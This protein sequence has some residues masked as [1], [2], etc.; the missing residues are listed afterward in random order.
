MTRIRFEINGKKGHIALPTFT[1]ATNSVLSILT[2][3]G[4]AVP[5]NETGRL[6][7]YIDDLS[8]NGSLAIELHAS[9]RPKRTRR[10]IQP[11][12]FSRAVAHSFVQGLENLETRGTSP[13]FL[14]QGGLEKMHRMLALLDGNGAR[15]FTATLPDTRRHVKVGR[16]AAENLTKLLPARRTERGSVEGRLETI[17][18]HGAK[19]FVVYDSVTKKG[20]TCKIEDPMLEEVKDA[21]GCKVLVSGSVSINEKNEPVA[22]IVDRLRSFTPSDQLPRAVDL[23][24]SDPEFTGGIS[25]REYL[26]RARSG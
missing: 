10:P 21:L 19:R 13:P 23:T 6:V 2:E 7:W 9:I 15:G 4:R 8:S 1:R 24:G 26:R 25:T 22:V 14:T 12:D 17:S 3:I 18:I 5:D 16:A 20:V 11:K